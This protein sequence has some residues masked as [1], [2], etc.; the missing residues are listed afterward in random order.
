MA[1]PTTLKSFFQTSL[2]LLC[3]VA[4]AQFSTASD[5]NSF[6]SILKETGVRGGFV[7]KLGVSDSASLKDLKFNAS[8]QVQGLE[9][10][11]SK[12]ATIRKQLV[13]DGVYGDVAIDRLIGEQLPYIDNLVNLFVSEDL[14]GIAM[15]EV[16]RVL[17]PEGVAYIKAADGSWKKTVKP[18]PADIDDWTHYFHDA[19]GNAVAH[20]QQVGPP[21]HLQWV[22]SPRYSRHHDRMAS[23]SALVSSAGRLFY[24]MDEGSRISIQLPSKWKLIARD[25]FNGTVLWKHDIP[26]WQNHLWPLKSGPTQLSRRLIADGQSVY[27]TL[28]HDA[29]LTCHDAATGEI[30][31]TYADTAGTEEVIKV[32]K[33]LFVVARKG[34]AELADYAPVNGRVGDQAL[35]RNLFWNEEARIVMA[36]DADSGKQLWAKQTKISPL[37]LS[38]DKSQIYFHDG[39]TITAVNQQ[40]GEQIWRSKSVTRRNQFNFNFGPRL[41]VHED[42]ILFAG[43]D[44]QMLGLAA[45][46][47]TTLW[48]ATHPNSGYQSPQD[49]MVVGGL[50]WCAPTT[51]GKD[52]G[53]FT[54]R[55]PRTGEVK[56]EFPPNVETY[57]FHHRCYIAKATDRFIIPSRTG[58]EFVDPTQKDWDIHHWVRGGCLYGIMPCNGL[59]YTPP[60][61]CACYPEAKLFGFNSL[62]PLAPTR[63]VPTQVPEEGRLEKGAVYSSVLADKADA[64]SS[65]WPTF[66]HDAARSGNATTSVPAAVSIKWEVPL[67]GR[68]T[69]PVVAGGKVFIGQ[70]DSHTL[71]AL[72]QTSGATLWKHT[73]G[74]RIDSPP[75]VVRGRVLFGGCDG[76]VYCL[77]AD[78]GTLAWRYR[79]APLDRRTMAYEQL[80]SL[81]PVHGSV[82]VRDQVVYA[83]AGRS[84]FLDGGLRMVRL[85]LATGKKLSETTMDETNPETGNNLQEKVKTLQMPVGLPD[86]L[87]ADE[88]FVYMKSQKFD[89]EGNRLKIGP[90]SGDAAEQASVQR[91]DGEHIFAPMGFLDDSWY[92]RSYWVHGQSFAGGHNGYYQAGKFAPSGQILVK[93]NGY[94]FGYGRKPEYLRWTTTMERQLFAAEQS[95]PEISKPGNAEGNA[96]AGIAGNKA[97]GDQFPKSPSLNPADKPITLEAWVTTTNPNGVIACMGGNKLGFAL[98]LKQGRPEFL[99]RVDGELATV[100]G[101]KRIVGGWHHLVGVLDKDS[102]MRLYVDGKRVAEGKSTKGLLPRV[103]ANAFSVGLNTGSTVGDYEAPNALT[104]II[105]EVRLYFSAASDESVAK[106]FED[107]TELGEDPHLVLT[108]DDESFRDLSLFNNNGTPGNGV[109]F[110]DGKVGR[111]AKFSGAKAVGE[112]QAPGMSL[113]KPKWASDV[114]IYVRAMALSG[115][116]LFMAGPPDII[117]EEKT[118][119]QIAER[120]KSVQKLLA[121]QDEAILGRFG[122]QLMV[123]N[124][125]TGA[126]VHQMDLK[127]TPA[128]DGMALADEMVF[129]T[130]LDGK[131]L[132]LGK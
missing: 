44:G 93:G 74:A 42:V 46:D 56:Q 114:P 109:T 61:N 5:P 106:R 3:C 132:C 126:V 86:V 130:T 41:V 45:R 82:L 78:D 91:G 127:S 118:F 64:N 24:I 131:V 11:A 104:G 14:S 84:N 116:L 69:A 110:A 33:L 107:G 15:D 101:P 79:V 121:E 18:R 9:R 29:P 87:S 32:G 50:V 16:L 76:W 72:D 48:S 22:G 125:Q 10:E 103:P 31:R 96:A 6:D 119:K 95:P 97:A 117:D 39:E 55:D 17:V 73:I 58:V 49:L 20:D 102:T 108:F 123:V 63:P 92:H 105:D 26:A 60:H 83:V 4:I 38:A 122:G 111:G 21:R 8:F 43:G 40:T 120:D 51:A 112:N 7:V 2:L 35:A 66:R 129:M 67:S 59:T 1:Q 25:A 65:D 62:A 57:W 71:H 115:D 89:F 94:V 54:G 99:M 30:V 75:T 47:G 12:V 81:W 128:W 80:E 13:A 52:T 85:D 37:T 70:T 34:E 28:G 98:T 36:F 88:K 124:T 68:L 19:T 100:A 113:V 27:V 53:V 90:H 23:M 77:Q